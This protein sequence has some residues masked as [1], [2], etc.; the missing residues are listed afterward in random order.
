MEPDLLGVQ[1]KGI[2]PVN[3]ILFAAEDVHVVLYLAQLPQ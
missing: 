3:Q 1:I 2:F